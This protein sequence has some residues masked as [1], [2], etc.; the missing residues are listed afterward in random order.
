MQMR[1]AEAGSFT[2]AACASASS[3]CSPG[4]EV[5]WRLQLD[6]S[7]GRAIDAS[8]RRVESLPPATLGPVLPL[9]MEALNVPQGPVFAYAFY[10]LPHAENQRE[11]AS[12]RPLA[13]A[14]LAALDCN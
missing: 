1:A 11:A 14:E 4:R 12:V 3:A 10:T 9:R 6:A 2:D 13:I 8:C 5:K 7:S